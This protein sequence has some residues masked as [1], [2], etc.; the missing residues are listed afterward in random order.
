MSSPCFNKLFLL[1][2]MYFSGNCLHL[3]ANIGML[4]SKVRQTIQSRA[5]FNKNV[6][7]HFTVP[8]SVLGTVISAGSK[9]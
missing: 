7:C 5:Q 4:D 9:T 2:A 8:G 6:S 1:W 3:K